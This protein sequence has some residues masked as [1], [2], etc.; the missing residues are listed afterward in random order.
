MARCEFCEGRGTIIV[1]EYDEDSHSWIP[2]GT[3]ACLCITGVLQEEV[4]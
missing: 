3:K 1:P 2:V 4:N